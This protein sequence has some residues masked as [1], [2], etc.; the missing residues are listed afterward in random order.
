MLAIWQT[1]EAHYGDRT[2]FIVVFPF[3]GFR[4]VAPIGIRESCE[5]RLI[6]TV[7]ELLIGSSPLERGLKSIFI[8]L[9]VHRRWC[10]IMQSRWY[11]ER[12][13]RSVRR[14]VHLAPLHL[15]S[16]TSRKVQQDSEC[17][18]FEE[19]R[20]PWV[21]ISCQKERFN[22]VVGYCD[23]WICKIQRSDKSRVTYAH[24]ALKYVLGICFTSLERL[25]SQIWSE[26]IGA[27]P[28]RQ[29]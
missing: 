23:L 9:L 3:G 5:S 2:Y 14:P 18:H 28:K 13:A 4:W 10:M 8:V 17:E 21:P 6:Q 29:V 11:R 12:F 1:S 24:S 15:D 16:F 20:I 26:V 7:H 27:H 19:T 25:W 22:S